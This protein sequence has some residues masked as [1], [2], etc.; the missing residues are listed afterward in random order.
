MKIN[1]INNLNEDEGP[2]WFYTFSDVVAWELQR[3]FHKL[4]VNTRRINAKG[5]VTEPPPIADHTIVISA[6]AMSFVRDNRDYATRLR[7]SMAGQLCL[8]LDSDAGNWDQY[9]DCVFSVIQPKKKRL[10]LNYVYAGWGAS[11]DLFY[12]DQKE[13]TLYLDSFLYGHPKGGLLDEVFDEYTRIL[14]TTGIRI[15]NPQ[16]HYDGDGRVAWLRIQEMLRA[17]HFFCDTKYGN[18]GLIRLEAATCGALL[19]VNEK[20][21]MPRTMNSLECRIWTTESELREILAMETN[22]AEIRKRA[23]EHSWDKAVR[24]IL[25]AFEGMSPVSA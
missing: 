2:E 17:C 3:S 12:P 16:P 9:F 8:Y 5:I 22:P 23:L 6:V 14:P 21:Y 10:S 20:T 19:V 25:D 1:L 11:P 18:S 13:K 7:K 24:R 15:Y 4:G